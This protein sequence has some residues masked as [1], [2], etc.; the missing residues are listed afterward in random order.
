MRIIT[1][2]DQHLAPGWLVGNYSVKIPPK[3]TGLTAAFFVK[4]IYKLETGKSSTPWEKIPSEAPSGDLSIEG[5]PKQGIGYASDFVPYK[6]VADFTAVATAYPPVGAKGFFLAR[7]R[8]GNKEKVIKVYGERSWTEDAVERPGEPG[9]LTSIPITYAS[10]WGGPLDPMNPLGC[11]RTGKPMPRLEI[12]ENPILDRQMSEAPAVFA[13]MPPNSPY[14]KSKT[15]TYD[16]EWV[17]GGWPWLPADFDYSYYNAAHPSQWMEAYLQGDEEL[18]LENMHPTHPVYQTRLP[19]IRVRCFVNRITNWSLELHSDDALTNFEEVPMDLDTLWVDMESEKLVLTWRGR[20]PI[21]SLKRRDL[22]HLFILTEPLDQAEKELSH[23]HQIYLEEL[24]KKPRKASTRNPLNPEAFCKKHGIQSAEEI[25]KGVEGKLKEEF[26]KCSK[27][28]DQKFSAAG[29]QLEQIQKVFPEYYSLL[30][31]KFEK[32]KASGNPFE[33]YLENPKS[34]PKSPPPM[35]IASLRQKMEKGLEIASAEIEKNH[36]ELLSNPHLPDTKKSEIKEALK[37]HEQRGAETRTSMELMEKSF[38][39]MDDKM[40]LYFPPKR[41][42][43]TFLKDRKPDLPKIRAEGLAN[44]DL[45]DIDLS[46][47]DLSG[48]D[49]SQ[50]TILQS[51]LAGCNLTGANFT[52]ATMMG[53]DLSDADLSEAILDHVNLST[54]MVNGTKLSGVSLTMANL[55]FLKLTGADL[56]GATGEKTI[57]TGAELAKANFAGA[58]FFKALFTNALLERADFSK[59]S[60]IQ[61]SM[62]VARAS[63][64]VMDDAILTKLSAGQGADFTGGRFLRA[65]A[66]GSSWGSSFLTQ[67]NFHQA[68]LMGAMFSDAKLKGVHFDRCNL[69][70]AHFDDAY[71]AQAILTNCNLMNSNFDRADLCGARLDNSNLY[72]ASFWSTLLLQATWH[73]A[74]ITKTNLDK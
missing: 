65:S 17:D 52:K 70:G 28:W 51:K 57:F 73:D 22:E 37:K 34:M 3:I 33:N 49:F 20:T 25:K 35:S 63:E 27:Q 32:A 23:Y 8:V 15:G 12:P 26:T 55:S 11:G 43:E 40:A 67:A 64:I 68:D 2:S 18:V 61:C 5:N 56:S 9:E 4:A 31:S 60:L 54:S 72:K 10:A 21:R 59:A 46:G 39:E 41:K 45:T 29:E 53:A 48:V 7:M 24:A 74:N 42:W 1:E 71:M 13:P 36:E 19:G 44:V 47:L 69:K 16:Q 66:Q 14:R 50:S 58:K 30:V 6:P 62:T 38:K